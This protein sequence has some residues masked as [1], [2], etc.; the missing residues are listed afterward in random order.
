ME[1]LAYPAK[2]CRTTQFE[3]LLYHG[4]TRCEPILEIQIHENGNC[5]PQVVCC[6]DSF[7][8]NVPDPLG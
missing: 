7:P 6:T 2:Q 4:L 5:G 3:P 1:R 8:D